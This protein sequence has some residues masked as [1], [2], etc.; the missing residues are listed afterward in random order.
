MSKNKKNKK[1]KTKAEKVWLD[2]SEPGCS[3]GTCPPA[4]EDAQAFAI[5][6]ESK[7]FTGDGILAVRFRPDPDEDEYPEYPV[8]TIE[9]STNEDPVRSARATSA[10]IDQFDQ[11]AVKAVSDAIEKELISDIEEIPKAVE[12]LVEAVLAGDVADIPGDTKADRKA[13]VSEAME[14]LDVLRADF[15][16]R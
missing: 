16:S 7:M 1:N 12:R 2:M 6:A 11:F 3:C 15:R 10:M 8:I 4:D 9:M 14:V 13:F 5:V